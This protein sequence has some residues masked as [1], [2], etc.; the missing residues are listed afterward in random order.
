VRRSLLATVHIG[1]GEP[2]HQASLRRRERLDADGGVESLE[3]ERSPRTVASEPLQARAVLALDADGAVDRK[4][5]LE[6]QRPIINASH[7]P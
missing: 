6:G 4:A 2:V 3:G 5:A 7:H 1:L